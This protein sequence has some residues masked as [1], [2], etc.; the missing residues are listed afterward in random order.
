MVFPCV[1]FGPV[2]FFEFNRLDTILLSLVAT[3]TSCGKKFKLSLAVIYS[4]RV[5][6]L[7]LLIEL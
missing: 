4:G 2:L 5:T 1:V 6:L 3:F 7:R